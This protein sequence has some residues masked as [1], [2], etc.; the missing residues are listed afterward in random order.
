M[1]PVRAFLA[2]VTA[3]SLARCAAFNAPEVEDTFCDLR[4]FAPFQAINGTAQACATCLFPTYPYINSLDLSAYPSMDFTDRWIYFLG[5]VTVRQIYGE[6]AA[7][8]HR[9]Q[10]IY[11]ILL[12][13][14]LNPSR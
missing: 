7:I 1:I 4:P 11:A 3:C 9:A 2:A 6:F 12:R 5:D 14:C 10:V 13:T 8:V